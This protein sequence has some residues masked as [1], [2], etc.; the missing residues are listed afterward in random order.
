[1]SE[2]WTIKKVLNWTIEY[3]KSQSVPEPRLSAELLLS[4]VLSCCR[5]DLYLNFN[6]MLNSKELA[7]FREYI[8]RRSRYEPVQYILGEYDFIG[9]K[10]KIT[11]QVFIPRHETELLVENV[12]QE[13]K[14]REDREVEILDVGTGSGNIAISLAHF[15]P[16]CRVTAVDISESSI[17]LARENAERLNVKQIEFKAL[18]ARKELITLQKKFDFIVSNPPYVAEKDR[19]QLHPQVSRYEPERA[20]FAGRCFLFGNWI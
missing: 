19:D 17:E 20:L 8:K 15:C 7:Q 10:F 14:N 16:E 4:H 13:I 2:I 1:M 5:L 11:P 6:Q 9:L 12:L 18:D 3:F